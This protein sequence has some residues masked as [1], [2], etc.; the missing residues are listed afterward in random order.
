[1]R[2]IVAS[3][4]VRVVLILIAS[5]ALMPG[6]GGEGE[7]ASDGRVSVAAAFYPLALAAEEIGGDGVDVRNLTPPGAEPHDVELSAR[8]VERIR[9]ADL[10]LYVGS[11]FQPDFERAAEGADGEVLDLLEDLQLLSGAEGVDPHVWLD[12]LRYEQQARLVGDA[13]DRAAEADRFGA[14]LRR[15]DADFKRGLARCERREIITSH[16]AFGYLADRYKLKQIAL[17]GLTPEAEP[18]ARDLERLIAEVERSE[19][20]TVFSETLASPD[21]A[22]TVAR[23]AGAKT[24]VLNPLEGLS[25]EELEAGEDYFSVMRENLAT[26][27]KALGCR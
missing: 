21:L 13:L 12:P 1:M 27:R 5:L 23:E 6:C 17:T 11:G 10:V 7:E 4:I 24:A 18:T 14:R 20:T 9:S 8:D 19:A 25:E 26:L 2:C 16:A 22:E 3:V 15:L